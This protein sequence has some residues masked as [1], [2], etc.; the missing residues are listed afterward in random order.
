MPDY[1]DRNSIAEIENDQKQEALEHYQGVLAESN[2]DAAALK[3]IN[4][5]G[6]AE[7][8]GEDQDLICQLLVERCTH[9]LMDIVANGCD[10]KDPSLQEAIESARMVRDL[11]NEIQGALN[12]YYIDQ[13]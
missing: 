6:N 9:Q 3:A 10:L 13:V 5:M 8:E 12:E 4:C 2:V 7:L 11:V 1:Q